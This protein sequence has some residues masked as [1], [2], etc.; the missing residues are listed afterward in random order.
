MEL[1]CSCIL[2]GIVVILF[3]LAIIIGGFIL[4]KKKMGLGG[5]AIYFPGE[6][7]A[8]PLETYDELNP[9]YAN[10]KR[11]Q[12]KRDFN[13]RNQK[14][15]ADLKKQYPAVQTELD[16]HRV[17]NPEYQTPV[18]Q[19]AKPVAQPVQQVAP[20]P[21]VAATANQMLV[22][23]NPKVGGEAPKAIQMNAD[24]NPSDL[25]KSQQNALKM[26]LGVGAKIEEQNDLFVPTAVESYI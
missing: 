24:V 7:I 5:S 10:I 11:M 16:F 22:P 3:I 26:Y 12:S 4:Y 15:A 2:L 9:E 23:P 18:Q 19:V 13:L 21:V 17:I 25:S 20:T 14:Q 6:N 8:E 1:N